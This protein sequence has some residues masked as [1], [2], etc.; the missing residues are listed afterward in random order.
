MVY[1]ERSVSKRWA[2]GSP[3][4]QYARVASFAGATNSALQPPGNNKFARFTRAK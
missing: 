2:G 3:V 1:E 4:C